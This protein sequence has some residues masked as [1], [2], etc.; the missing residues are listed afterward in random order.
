V[1]AGDEYQFYQALV[2]AWPLDL[3]ATDIAGWSVFTQRMLAWR[4]KSLH[5]QKLR[6]S[7]SNPDKAFEAA[8]RDFVTAALDPDRSGVFL[9]RAESF[10]KKLAPAGALNGLVQ[11]ALRCTVPGMPDCFQGRELWDFSMVD[12]DNRRPVDYFK[13][14]TMLAELATEAST[15]LSLEQWESGAPKLAL[16]KTLLQLRARYPRCFA[17]GAYR[18]LPVHGEKAA[19]VLAFIREAVDVRTLVAVPLHVA[20]ACGDVPLSAPHFWGDTAWPLPGPPTS[21]R[22]TL[23]GGTC[24]CDVMP[25]REAFARFP[26][27]ALVSE[28]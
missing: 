12:P 11:T 28:T 13:R 14:Q 24:E 3:A 18:P 27:C 5:E 15:K 25:A 17:R 1:E 22:D 23:Q 16:L 4:E 19:H 10:L 21:W 26:V 8:H 7:W 2:A 20:H 6:T 9:R